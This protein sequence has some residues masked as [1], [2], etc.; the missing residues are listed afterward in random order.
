[1]Q[2]HSAKPA[3]QSFRDSDDFRQF[4]RLLQAGFVKEGTDITAPELLTFTEAL[5]QVLQRSD[6][7]DSDTGQY[8]RRI[9]QQIN[10]LRQIPDT[11]KVEVE[12]RMLKARLAYADGR[13]TISRNFHLI[14]QES[15]DSVLSCEHI[16]SQLPGL[17]GFLEALYGYYYYHTQRDTRRRRS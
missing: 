12:L 2:S 5:A 3:R 17:C 10:G 6:R 15:I 14:M 1:M 13:Q 9:V 11:L 8:F 4:Q 16:P 7:H